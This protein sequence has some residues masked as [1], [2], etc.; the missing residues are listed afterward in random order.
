MR[1]RDVMDQADSFLSNRLP[2]ETR[3][4]ILRHTANCARCRAEIADRRRLRVAL[5]SSLERT[6]SLRA[7]PEFVA[8][9]GDRVRVAG[10][11][12]RRATRRWH[13]GL[14]IAAGL[15]LAL[16]P[17]AEWGRLGANQFATLARAAAGDHEN[18]ALHFRLNEKPISLEEAGRRFGPAY[19]RLAALTPSPDRLPRGPVTVLERHACVFNGRRFAHIVLGYGGEAVSVLIVPG[20]DVPVPQA[21][22][23]ID[24]H[25]VASFRA[26]GYVVFVVSPFGSEETSRIAETMKA[27]ARRA[28]AGV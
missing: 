26:A 22:Q 2:V 8:S 16:V 5:R 7:R 19:A 3:H 6:P 18:C 1:C 12:R 23:S 25:Q 27:P 28:L 10:K 4:E 15:L 24:G 21:V 17:V 11:E 20:V 13:A 9:I 14:V